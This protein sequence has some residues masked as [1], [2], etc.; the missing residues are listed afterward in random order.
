MKRR[1]ICGMALLVVVSGI[2]VATIVN[3]GAP[4]ALQKRGSDPEHARLTAMCGVWDV[5]LTFWFQPGGPG[6]TTKG[7][8]TIR[9]LFGTRFTSRRNCSSMAARFS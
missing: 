6:V 5:E 2:A 8:S 1:Q 7:T 4:A 9:P 3:A